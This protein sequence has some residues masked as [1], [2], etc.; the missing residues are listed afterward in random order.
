[1]TVLTVLLMVGMVAV[2]LVGLAR[3]D[4]RTA[5]ARAPYRGADGSTGFYGGSDSGSG[6]CG[7]S[8]GG[9]CD[10]GGGGGD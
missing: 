8:D 1:M 5:R 3:A 10:G 7:G 2:L 9:G 6:D 4:S